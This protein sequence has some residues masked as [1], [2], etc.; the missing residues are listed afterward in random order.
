MEKTIT[1]TGDAAGKIVVALTSEEMKP[2][3]DKAYDNARQNIDLKGF[4]KGKVPR[5]MIKKLYGP[6]VEGEAVEEAISHFLSDIFQQ[7]KIPV[8][9]QPKVTNIDHKDDGIEF[10]V[11]FDKMPDFELNDYRGITIDEPVH[12][13]SDEEIEEEITKI[14]LNNGAMV[15]CEQVTDENHVVRVT[16]DEIDSET[17]VPI[18]GAKQEETNIFLG[19]ETVIPSLKS[20]LLNTKAEDSFSFNPGSQ[21]KGAPDKTYKITVKEIQKVVPA[22]FTNEFVEKHTQGKL[23]STE[24]YRDELGFQ[25][26]EKWDSKSREQMEKQVVD[27]IADAHDFQPPELLVKQTLEAFVENLK[28]QYKDLPQAE[29]MTVESME[30]ELR[31]LAE[32]T[33]KWELIQ[34]K[35][36]EKEDI[37]VE[38]HDIEEIVNFQAERMNADKETVKMAVMQNPRITDNII[39]KKVIDLLLDFAITQETDFDGNPIEDEE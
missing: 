31:P 33:V 27:K 17:G 23:V 24:E 10:T 20:S 9:G 37:Q 22:E 2:F 35:I 3:Y 39:N 11:E 6:Q 26:Q 5:G 12:R 32:R 15:P 14:C 25:L 1:N 21:E 4:R 16:L 8:L 29:N 28:K 36:I 13:V 30:S 34:R 38:D 18:V 7:E 19:S